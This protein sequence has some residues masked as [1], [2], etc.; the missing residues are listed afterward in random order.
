[1]LRQAVTGEASHI[2]ADLEAV[3]ALIDHRQQELRRLALQLGARVYAEKPKPFV[4]RMRAM[5]R[6][7]RGQEAVAAEQRP[8]EL[9]QA[10]RSAHVV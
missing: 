6:A 2:A 10:T 4:R 3:L 9:A 5:W 1:M 7:G 8:A